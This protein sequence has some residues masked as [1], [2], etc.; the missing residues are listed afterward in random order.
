MKSIRE[1]FFKFNIYYKKLRVDLITN[2]A[3][4]PRK[5]IYTTHNLQKLR[6]TK[7]SD[8]QLIG[9]SFNQKDM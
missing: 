1:L 8:V 5:V 2:M 6:N 3:E 9:F 7:W 4:H